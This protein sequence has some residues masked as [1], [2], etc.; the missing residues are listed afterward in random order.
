MRE[1]PSTGAKR[2]EV[3][4]RGQVLVVSPYDGVWF[5]AGPVKRNGYTWYAV[6]K[7]QTGDADGDLPALPT[8]PILLGTEVEIG[9]IATDD[10]DEDYV[11]LLAPRC[12][13]TVD[14]RN[15][16]AMLSWERLSCLDGQFVLEGIYGCPVCGAELTGDFE[17][18][19]LS[20]PQALDF[21][22]I[23]APA[24]VGPLILRFPPEVE[25]PAQSSI[26]RATVHVDDPRARGCTVNLGNGEPV[27][28]ATTAE[29]YCRSQ[30]VVDSFEVLG[31]DPDFNT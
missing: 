9:W 2:V 17:P 18:V 20:Y 5:G 22:S 21:L 8:R 26:I 19:W 15:V 14:L 25:S 3:L 16:Q 28:P 13:G 30:V 7:L 31:V 6:I 11:K 29:L 23:D 1:G 24:S 27:T 10:G 4:K 12:P